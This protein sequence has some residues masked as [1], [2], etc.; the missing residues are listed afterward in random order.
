MKKLTLLLGLII[1]AGCNPK[2]NSVTASVATIS[3]VA[4]GT[5]CS[6]SSTTSTSSQSVYGTVYD[7]SQTAYN[8]ENRVKDL[9]SA[10]IQPSSVGTISSGQA[11]STGVRFSGHIKVDASGNVVSANSKVVISV[12]DSV[13]LMD[14][15]TT[16]NEKEIQLTFDPNAGTGAVLSGQIDSSGSGYISLKDKFGEVRFDNVKVDAQNFSGVMSFQNAANIAGGANSSGTVGQFY[17]QRCA[18]LQ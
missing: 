13:W 18:F 10:T 9:L 12:Y 14:L 17:I 11:D 5:Q 8:F 3:G 1:L 7:N 4:V 2:K 15:Y 6:N 16:P